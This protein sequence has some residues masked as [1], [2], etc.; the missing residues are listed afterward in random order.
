MILPLPKYQFQCLSFPSFT[1]SKVFKILSTLGALGLCSGLG[2]QTLEK[3][4]PLSGL[5]VLKMK[6]GVNVHIVSPEPIEFVDLSTSYLVGDLPT[7]NLARIKVLPDSLSALQKDR[8]KTSALSLE[9]TLG[10]QELDLGVITIVGKSFMAQYRAVYTNTES[11]EIQSSLY[12]H[13][14]QMQPLEFLTT[15]LS[16]KELLSLSRRIMA[17]ELV[18]PLGKKKGFGLSLNLNNLYVMGD[19]VFVDLL[20]ENATNLKYDLE[21]LSFSVE[22][23]KIYKSTNNQSIPLMPLY[24]LNEQQ[25]FKKSYRNVFVFEKFSFPNSKVLRIRLVEQELSGRTLVLEI[26]YSALLKADTL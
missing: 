23:K 5:V 7:E 17:R 15:A 25:E 22:D 8:Q 20:I 2:A 26:P 11:H 1:L 4:M 14:D 10:Y 24:K 19:Y 21:S 18:K 3:E 6:P 9:S 16:V 13:P 12:I